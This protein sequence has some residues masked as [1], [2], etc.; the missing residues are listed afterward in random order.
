M[1]SEDGRRLLGGA[2]VAGG[3]EIGRVDGVLL[4]PGGEHVLGLAVQV[5]FG[6][7]GRFLPTAAAELDGRI[8][9]VA[10]IFSLLSAAECG[11]YERHGAA[12]M[13]PEPV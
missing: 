7:A 4:D 9:R 5:A 10:S 1:T 6:G 11:F 8:V 12:W 13:T 2:V 3:V